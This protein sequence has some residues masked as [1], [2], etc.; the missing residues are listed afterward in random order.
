MIEP[1]YLCGTLNYKHYHFLIDGKEFEVLK[2][3]N[4]SLARTWPSPLQGNE[5]EQ[6]YEDIEDYEMRFEKQVLWQAFAHRTLEVIKKYKPSGKLLDVGCNVGILVTEAKK[7]GY[8]AYG[9]D[10]SQKALD[11]GRK[12]LGLEDSLQRGSVAAQNY[13]NDYWDIMTY[14]QCFE[15]LED[16]LVE[17]KEVYKVIKPEGILV[18]EVPRFFSAWRFFLG[19]YWYGFVPSQH[20][21]Q[22]GLLGVTSVLERAGFEI[23]KTKTRYNLDH[24][25]GFNLK[26]LVKLFIFCI[27]WIT[28]TGDLL[29]I[30]ARKKKE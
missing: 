26:G 14:M 15:H 29:I 25:F 9:I 7:L 16:P 13:P 19:K 5:A 3:R 24:E 11:Y 20:V 17:Y 22:C 6:Y 4:C 10:F 30:V 2:C 21:W 23:I 8:D 27:A 12:N 28:G 18:I 1:C